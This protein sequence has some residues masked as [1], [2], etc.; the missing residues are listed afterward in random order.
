M[1][2]LSPTLH[3]PSV[4]TPPST[5]S[6][7]D[8]IYHDDKL[9]MWTTFEGVTGFHPVNPERISCKHTQTIPAQQWIIAHN[10]GTNDL[11][12][13]AYDAS[14]NLMLVNRS[15]VDQNNML[16]EFSENVTG[17]A[18]VFCNKN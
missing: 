15:I 13:A 3:V 8:V 5:G 1:A 16:L 11:I 14:D 6:S 7:G 9:K 2:I 17:Y 18:I 4:T 12:Y 10:F